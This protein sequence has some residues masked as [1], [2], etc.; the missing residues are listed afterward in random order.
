[1]E[2]GMFLSIEGVLLAIYNFIYSFHMPLFFM[3]SGFVFYRAYF[4]SMNCPKKKR[5][6]WQLFNLVYVYVVFSIIY[7]LFKII[8]SSYA[9]EHI[10]FSDLLLIWINPLGEYWYL[11]V[12]IFIY[13]IFSFFKITKINSSIVCIVSLVM[14]LIGQIIPEIFQLNNVLYFGF[15][16]WIGIMISQNNKV[17]TNP[18]FCTVVFSISLV[19]LIFSIVFFDNVEW[20]LKIII[21]FGISTGLFSIFKYSPVIGENK[22]LIYCGQ[23][24]LEIY[25]IHNYFNV[26]TRLICRALGFSNPILILA[27]YIV[28]FAISLFGS[29][30]CTYILKK[31]KIHDYLFRLSSKLAR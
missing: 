15:Y 10:A 8:L 17:I 31:L 9:N 2:S 25:V 13:V 21:A 6:V 28:S 26:I 7:G 16:F 19:L 29:L 20:S 3:I 12:L 14:C 1:M 5:I 24:S 22:F 4:D 18:L 23:R 27:A 11:Y 30:I